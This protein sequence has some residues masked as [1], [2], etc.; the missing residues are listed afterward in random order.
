VVDEV[1]AQIKISAIE[2]RIVS[3]HWQDRTSP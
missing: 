3:L 2:N 1:I